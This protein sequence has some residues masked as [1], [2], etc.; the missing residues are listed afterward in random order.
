LLT[1]LVGT[2]LEFITGWNNGTSTFFRRIGGFFRRQ[3]CEHEGE[4]WIF[5]VI[6]EKLPQVKHKLTFSCFTCPSFE[7]AKKLLLRP[8]K[9]SDHEIIGYVFEKLEQ[10]YLRLL[11]VFMYDIISSVAKVERETPA[12]L[13]SCVKDA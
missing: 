3:F 8:Q 5:I 10:G 13:L 7:D 9:L 1:D 2:L 6:F 11:T 4:S 12:R